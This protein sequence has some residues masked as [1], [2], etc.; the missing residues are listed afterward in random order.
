MSGNTGRDCVVVG[1]RYLRHVMSSYMEYYNGARTH[2][3]LSKTRRSHVQCKRTDASEHSQFSAGSAIN[4]L[5][6]DLR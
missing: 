2:L 3:S 5:G 1:E 4:M 6:F